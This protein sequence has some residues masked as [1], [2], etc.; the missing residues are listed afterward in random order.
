[1]E[2]VFGLKQI[3]LSKHRKVSYNF[4]KKFFEYA[5]GYSPSLKQ[6]LDLNAMIPTEAEA[7]RMKDLIR[8]VL[9]YSLE[10]GAE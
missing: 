7:C 5:N 8:E 3:L 6:R 1:M 9:V 4:A 10:G 2:N